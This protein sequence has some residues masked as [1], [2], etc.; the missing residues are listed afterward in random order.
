MWHL[1][2]MLLYRSIEHRN[3]ERDHRPDLMEDSFLNPY[4]DTFRDP[5][6]N[7]EEAKKIAA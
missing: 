7:P 3:E 1:Q 4:A 5:R 2:G 6:V